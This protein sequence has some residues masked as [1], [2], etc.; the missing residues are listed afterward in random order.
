M[1]GGGEG[2]R[3][4]QAKVSLRLSGSSERPAYPGF[5]VI[6]AAEWFE[7]DSGPFKHKGTLR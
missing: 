4:I 5:I 7:G 3:E 2:G 1:G 6:H